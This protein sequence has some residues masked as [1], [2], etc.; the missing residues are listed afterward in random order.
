MTTY[1]DIVLVLILWA[2]PAIQ[3]WF[4]DTVGDWT[5]NVPR[6][7]RLLTGPLYLGSLIA[8]FFLNS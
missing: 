4:Y 3:F 1:L 2:G 5:E 7:Q 8:L 6:W